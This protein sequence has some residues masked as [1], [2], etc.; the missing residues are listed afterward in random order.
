[1]H[2]FTEPNLLKDQTN[3]EL[4]GPV[5]TD[6][7]N[8]FNTAAVFEL[9]S[10]AK[11]F[12]CQ[13]CM[14]IVQEY[15]NQDLSIDSELVNIVLKPLSELDIPFPAVKYY[16][17]RGI[18]K[19]SFISGTA[20]KSNNPSTNSELLNKFWANWS[21]YKIDTSQ[22]SLADP[23]P[24]SFG[25]DASLSGTLN[26]EDIYNNSQADVRA[27]EVS[28]GEWIGDFALSTTSNNPV[29]I[30]F[31]IILDTDHIDIN[32]DYVKKSTNIID[33]TSLSSITPTTPESEFNLRS[34]KE[35]ILS[36]IDPAAFFGLHYHVGVRL[37]TF[38]G[39]NKSTNRKKGE[40]VY[41]TFLTGFKS[42]NTVYINITS[43]NG[44]SYNHYK[45][46]GDVNGF[47]LKIKAKSI[48]NFGNDLYYTFGWPIF[49]AN[50]PVG[51]TWLNKIQ[52]QLRVDDN[53]KPL[54]F[55]NDPKLLGKRNKKHFISNEKLLNGSNTDWSNTVELRF[56]NYGSGSSKV[57][58]AHQLQLQ[59]FR[60]EDSSGSPGT[61][62]KT[63]NL[64]D[65][66][67]GGIDMDSI[68]NGSNFNHHANT[69]RRYCAGSNFSFVSE[70][71][72]FFDT[73][74]MIFY[75]ENK[76]PLIESGFVYPNI[77]FKNIVD[78]KLINSP[79]LPKKILFNKW[80]IDETSTSSIEIL[81]IAVYNSESKST[82]KEGIFMLGLTKSEWN[83][84][85]TL[86]GVS[87]LHQKYLIFTEIPGQIDMDGIPFKKY[88]I[89]VQGLD[90]EGVRVIVAPTSDIFVYGSSLNMLCSSAFSSSASLP[91]VL[92]DPG[93]LK[94]WDYVGK[95]N[96]DKSDAIVNSVVTGGKIAITDHLKNNLGTTKPTIELVGEVYFPTD[97]S[98]G[99]TLSTVKT[100]YPLI[101]VVHGN[102][103]NY[104]DYASLNEHLA[105]NGFI[106]G[107][108]ECMGIFNDFQLTALTSP[109]AP[110]THTFDIFGETYYYSDTDHK[111]YNKYSVEIGIEGTDFTVLTGLKIH[112]NVDLRFHGMASI[113]RANAL[114]Y[115]LKVLKEKFTNK[116]QNN[117]G[118]MGHSRGGEAVV[119]AAKDIANQ[120]G[121]S[122]TPNLSGINNLNAI[123][124][125]AP[126][127]QYDKE[128]LSQGVPYFVIYGS[129][130]ADVEGSAKIGF[131][132]MPTGFALW[133]RASNEEKTMAFVYGASHNGFITSNSD[134]IR[135]YGH[136]PF[137]IPPSVQQNISYAYMNA[138]F[139]TYLL[140]EPY[141]KPF[142]IGNFIPT[143]VTEDRIYMQYQRHDQKFVLDDFE[144]NMEKTKSSLGGLVTASGTTVPII[145]EDFLKKI[146]DY[147][148]HETKAITVEWSGATSDAKLKFT[149]SP[150]ASTIDVSAY[151]HLSFRIAYLAIGGGAL[152]NLK[153]ELNDKT[154]E[155]RSIPDADKR[156][157][158]INTIGSTTY[159]IDP[160]KTAM[161]TIRI[162]LIEYDSLGVN[163]EAITQVAFYF[164]SG[165]GSGKVA[166]DSIEFTN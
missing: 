97:T 31:E 149:T 64:L 50:T 34:R 40:S 100:N 57:N 161:M 95:W 132:I 133:D 75:S 148:P 105:Q 14:M 152:S 61:V 162:P 154:I 52:I 157:D 42:R 38:S 87:N 160:T 129:R 48:T 6:P 166:I 72:C 139:R 137:L 49:Y 19:S 29:R 126:T 135:K 89:N 118:I 83:I 107:S 8:K 98:G 47:I 102:G 125:L 10:Q 116:L 104:K 1:M 77:N 112:L 11:A 46:Y 140:N 94:P 2:F 110:L 15:K 153:I 24:Q 136:S 150:A 113:G 35:E 122:G 44:Y 59:Y 66:V 155:I 32:L 79:F 147:S 92:R 120:N 124:S 18:L 143:S 41:S 86:I 103:Q 4:Y 23:T 13:K 93:T 106:A 144:T 65:A 91:S 37:S 131:N 58:I 127:D 17:Y 36:Y 163:L 128:I 119:R 141:W 51:T 43:E 130:D 21:Q 60:Q 16:I 82:K 45:N 90:N 70:S 123:I 78:A 3:N 121:S 151:S 81:D 53:S 115:H 33:V 164:P 111:I 25:F 88:K 67:F 109:T 68:A 117:I 69:K 73:D 9:T 28:E 96:Y 138:F 145:E 84:L 101:M 80:E 27:I 54:L 158:T 56:P 62:L 134:Y 99:T 114:F 156:S 74:N 26:V 71:G 108:I 5:V 159:K 7:T 22:P 146:D 165:G 142:L 20:I 30:A 76:Y 85:N 12:A 55:I 63:E 39:S